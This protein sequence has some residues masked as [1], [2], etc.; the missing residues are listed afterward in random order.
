M[1]AE[2]RFDLGR[3]SE[4]KTAFDKGKAWVE[5]DAAYGKRMKFA[6]DKFA[7]VL[8]E[9]M[10][11]DRKL[12]VVPDDPTANRVKGIFLLAR[13]WNAADAAPFLSKS[14]LPQ[15][16]RLGKAMMAAPGI[17]ARLEVATAAAAALAVVDG[18]AQYPLACL[19]PQAQRVGGGCA[20][21]AATEARQDAGWSWHASR[22]R[23][24]RQPVL[25]PV[26]QPDSLE[27][28]LPERRS[29]SSSI[30]QDP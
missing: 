21:S 30:V 12:A 19:G 20:K 15:L 16:A 13:G 1:L 25:R 8:Q 11:N 2:L 22:S 5:K 4:A 23:K 10:N 14:D 28:R 6:M 3:N 27:F 24:L 29:S 18:D 9:Q 26:E 7:F 17:P